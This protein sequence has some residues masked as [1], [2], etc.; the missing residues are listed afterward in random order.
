MLDWVSLIICLTESVWSYAW[1]SQSGHMLDW[2][3]QGMCSTYSVDECRKAFSLANVFSQGPQNIFW[4]SRN[5][6]GTVRELSSA[7]QPRIIGG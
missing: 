4:I 1:L 5:I 7:T 2:V 6:A 3:N